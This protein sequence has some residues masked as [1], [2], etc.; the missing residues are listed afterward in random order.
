MTIRAATRVP[1]YLT[2]LRYPGGKQRLGPFFASLIRLHD[3]G[4]GTYYEPFAGGAGV[5][6]YLLRH[7][8]VSAIRLNDLDRSIYAF[9]HSVINH[10]SKLCELILKTPISV[11][12]WDRQKTVQREKSSAPLLDLGFSTLFL[13]RTNRSGILRAGIIGGRKQSG[14]WRIDARYDRQEI[15]ARVSSLR[16]L[17]KRIS[18]QGLDAIDF[19]R[20]HENA[21]SEKDLVYLD[22][23]Y[24]GKGD[25]LYL[26]RYALSDHLQLSKY[27]IR[28]LKCNWIVTYDDTN[29]VRTMYKRNRRKFTFSY[30]ADTARVGSELM[31]G[32]ARLISSVGPLLRRGAN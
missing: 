17:A 4:G 6:L 29:R 22:P 27:V 10:N 11:R 9:W 16:P 12:E 7:D 2:P 19:L 18:I 25:D 30:S 20:F 15:A 21:W 26:N 5:A 28:K 13:N 23:P 31:I 3:L 32:S 24:V 1:R 8:L 14:V